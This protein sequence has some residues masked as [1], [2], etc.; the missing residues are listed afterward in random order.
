M[1]IRQQSTHP[2]LLS[3]GCY[4]GIILAF[5]VIYML[6]D[7]YFPKQMF[8]ERFSDIDG[9]YFSI[10][11]MA[12]VGFGDIT[13]IHIVSR[14]IVSVQILLGVIYGIT[15]FAVVSALISNRAIDT[16]RSQVKADDERADRLRR[17][18]ARLQEQEPNENRLP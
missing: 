11:T 4:L 15:I 7:V 13:P 3:I 8:K 10:T 17:E 1:V 6:L 2:F 5:G 14:A 12:T 16:L 18:L 9:I